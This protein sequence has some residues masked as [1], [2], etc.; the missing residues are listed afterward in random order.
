MWVPFSEARLARFFRLVAGEP[1]RPSMYTGQTRRMNMSKK[2]KV[3]FPGG[4]KVYASIGDHVVKTDQSVENGGTGA[5]AEPFD[6]FL[7]SMATCAGINASEF[8][9][10]KK[11]STQGLAL[12][13]D[14]LRDEQLRLYNHFR[15]MVRLPQDFPE[16][17]VADL[18]ST[19]Q[20]CAVKRH[21]HPDIT[22][23]I[24]CVKGLG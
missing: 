9:A 21:A 5:H 7:C 14:C 11:I 6:L 23:V 2:I 15:I 4:K 10:R 1:A 12:D 20:R 18:V 17:H 22:V 8:C 3:D 19:M 24:E 13:V 16:V